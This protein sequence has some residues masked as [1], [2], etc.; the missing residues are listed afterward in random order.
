MIHKN[1]LAFPIQGFADGI[2]IRQ[3]YAAK[4]LQGLLSSPDLK[5]I[6]GDQDDLARAC[7]RA[8]DALIK[9]ENEESIDDR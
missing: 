7:F 9:Y 6:H 8:A 5:Q 4:A 3:Y 1:D 2:T